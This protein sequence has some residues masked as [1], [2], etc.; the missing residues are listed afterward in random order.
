TQRASTAFADCARPVELPERDLTRAEVVSL[1][2]QDRAALITC[3]ARNAAGAGVDPAT[4][5]GETG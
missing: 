1:W 2:G 5:N 4:L 3:R